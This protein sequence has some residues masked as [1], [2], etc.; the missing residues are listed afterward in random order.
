[1]GKEWVLYDP[2]TRGLHV[3]NVAAALAW[4][5]LDGERTVESI[6]EEIRADM[7]DPPDLEVVRGDVEAAVAEFSRA[8]LLEGA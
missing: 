1:M 6:A 5:L 2:D 4:S 8:G 3:L 7:Q